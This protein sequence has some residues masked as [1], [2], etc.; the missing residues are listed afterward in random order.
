MS[1]SR[2]RVVVLCTANRCRSPLGGAIFRREAELLNLPVE[3]V[4]AG[5]SEPGL[6]ATSATVDSARDRDLD[7]SG[8]RSRRVDSALLAE[9]DLVLGMERAHVREAVVLE[10]SVWRHT[11]TLR[12]LVRRAEAAEPRAADE[13]LR[14][15]L[16]ALSDGRERKELMGSSPD[17][18]VADPTTDWTVD[19]ATTAAVIDDL[20]RRFVSRAWPS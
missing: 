3:V 7:L 17:D 14:N 19:H 13:S 18:D 4:T 16:E 12:E 1:D 8:H 15:W 10:P 9:A 20:V 5:F 6:P 2:A 11:F